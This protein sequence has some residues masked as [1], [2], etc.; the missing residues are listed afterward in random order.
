MLM[1]KTNWT[2]G[3]LALACGCVPI[4]EQDVPTSG[5]DLENR[6]MKS[7]LNSNVS[8]LDDPDATLL[9]IERNG[10][11]LMGIFGTK[12]YGNERLATY[13]RLH[14][15]QA[16]WASR[17]FVLSECLFPLV[18]ITPKRLTRVFLAGGLLFHALTA[19]IMGLNSFF[20][21][22][23]A[24]YPAIAYCNHQVTRHQLFRKIVRRLR[25]LD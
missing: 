9:R 22:F 12:A 2:K 20:W 11:A 3:I 10:S 14:P 19:A 24:T 8:G 15:S 17:L 1:S 23:G 7:K 5:K 25:L 21:S 4:S 16:A 6:F 18:L 13:L